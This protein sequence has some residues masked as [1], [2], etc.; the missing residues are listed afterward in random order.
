MPFNFEVAKLAGPGYSLRCLLF[1]D[2]SD[3][4]SEFTKG[5]GITIG[6]SQ[7]ETVIRFIS[8]YYTPVSLEDYL[9]RR[10]NADL[11]RRPVLV[12]F[13]DAYA[14]VAFNAAPIL[15]KYKVPAVFFVTASL[16]GN[17]E[18][19]LDNLICY[20]ANTAGM[21]TLQSVARQFSSDERAIFD[22][23]EQVFDHLLPTMPQD[24][25]AKFRT[26]LSS[27]AGISPTDLARNAKLYVS[28][29]QLKALSE[30]G[31]EIGSH[32]FSHVFCRSLVGRDFQQ[33][34]AMNKARLEAI[35]GARVRAFSV[36]YGSPV[37]LSS[38][39]ANHLRD[40]GHEIAF[41]ARDRSNPQDRDLYQLNRVSM[42]AG[43]DQDL[44][45]EIEILPRLRS[46]A[47]A[48]LQKNHGL[49]SMLHS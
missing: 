27:S 2:V 38:E 7:F 3:I 31:F 26:A 29:E 13:D 44:F 43:N 8:R 24:Q 15:Q 36:P 39:L 12:T 23:L 20:V 40:S 6:V 4:L 42:H 1:H 35:S 19:G 46:L 49:P 45:A 14:S 37:D 41:L 16:I 34:I 33:E 47:D 25:I 22:S 5:L 18:L 32:T 28:A 9:E 11:P 17:E 21:G 30:S 48:I 10:R